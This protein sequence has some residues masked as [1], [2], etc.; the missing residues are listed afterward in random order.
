MNAETM[1]WLNSLPKPDDVAGWNERHA[2]AF[3]DVFG[4][5][6][7]SGPAPMTPERDDDLP[8]L[9]DMD[10]QQLIE[11]AQASERG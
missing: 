10:E 2:Q 6:I 7:Y 8:G 1:K 3:R 4:G 11:A 9:S 5:T